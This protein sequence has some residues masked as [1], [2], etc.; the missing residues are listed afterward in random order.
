MSVALIS[1]TI[2]PSVE[3][4]CTLGVPLL[5]SRA[6]R[7]KKISSMYT[8]LDRQAGRTR[9]MTSIQSVIVPNGKSRL[10]GNFFGAILYQELI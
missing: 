6:V 5:L 10:V 7:N 4:K 2:Y 3:A 8:S 9:D 1:R